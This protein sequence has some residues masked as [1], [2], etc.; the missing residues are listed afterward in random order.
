M[1][2]FMNVSHKLVLHQ[3]KCISA[4]KRIH[5]CFST[6]VPR[7]LRVQ[8][9]VAMGSAETNRNCLGRNLQPQFYA[10]V[11]IYTSGSQTFLHGGT[12]SRM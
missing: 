12:V 8:S 10:V 11:A 2:S 9:V 7:N 1:T 4:Y 3:S 6:G 5:Q